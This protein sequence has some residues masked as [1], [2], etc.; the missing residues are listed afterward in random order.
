MFENLSKNP[1]IVIFFFFAALFVYSK[2]GPT[3]PISVISSEKGQPL[4][5][6]GEGKVVVIPDIAKVSVG[7]EESG[8]S[9]SQVQDSANQKSKNLVDAIKKLGVKDGDIKTTNYSLNPEYNYEIQPLRIIG[10][11]V[12]IT[13]EIEVKDFDKI[14]D[15]ITTST[16]EGS[17]LIGNIRFEV[18]EE[19][20]NKKLDEAREN[21][22]VEAKRKAQGLAKASGVSLGKI[23]NISESQ[24]FGRP[25]PFALE[26]AADT[27]GSEP[28][29][30]DIQPGQTELSVMVS[31]TFEIR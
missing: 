10:Y 30:P 20:K 4:V 8:S 29:R 25:I 17:T 22:V 3:L 19:T 5:V 1:L 31:L 26:K 7:I 14:N 9:L 23:I 27:T 16:T 12:N 21:A 28:V 13:Y 18:N 2:F 15:V 24:G 6:E 11:R